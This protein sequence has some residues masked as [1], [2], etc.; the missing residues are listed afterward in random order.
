MKV[1][2]IYDATGRI[3]A[4]AYEE[5]NKPEGVPSMFV[6][7]PDGSIVDRI[8]VSDPE[9]HKPVFSFIPIPTLAHWKRKSFRIRRIFPLSRGRWRR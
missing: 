4:E 6:D 5:L 8:D 2:A 9:N 3:W 1:L 7:I